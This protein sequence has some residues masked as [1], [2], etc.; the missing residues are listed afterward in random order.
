MK[1]ASIVL[2][3]MLVLLVGTAVTVVAQECYSAQDLIGEARRAINTITV[4]EAKRLLDSGDYMFIDVREPDEFKM[5]HIP[6]AVNIPRGL[7]EFRIGGQVPG[8]NAK[9]VV[10]CKSG[11]RSSLATYTVKV[12][13]GYVNA[14][15]MAG[16]WD[17]WL[18]AGYPV[19]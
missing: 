17:A 6:G 5:G 15:N 4:G 11:G 18:K 9:I 10:Y 16:G 13:M 3:A 2:G 14:L 1:K 8:K 19:E 7:L 12:K